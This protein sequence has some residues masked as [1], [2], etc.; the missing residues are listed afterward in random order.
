MF[1]RFP[2]AAE[3]AELEQLGFHLGPL[4]PHTSRTIMFADLEELL[5][6]V[7]TDADR[8]GYGSAV[9]EENVLGKK[10]FANRRE[11]LR[12]LRELYALDPR[13][14]LFRVFL[15]LWREASAGRPLLAVLAALARDPLLR[16]TA[17]PVV[18]LEPGVG[19]QR[20]ILIGPLR[21]AA[22]GRLNEA[23][24]DKV[25]RYTASS[26]T[27]AGL[28]EG[29]VLK[30]RRRTDPSPETAA[31]ALWLAACEGYPVRRLLESPWCRL[32]DTSRPELLQLTLQA[33]R[34]GYIHARAAGDLLMIDTTM[35]DP[36]RSR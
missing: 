23:M 15:R 9:V 5:R 25:A 34:L 24:I 27:Q 11:S 6:A 16:A 32:C 14:P 10:T 35:A 22:A 30:V 33:N 36:A 28:L 31:L 21:E 8:A 13:V 29:R 12:R 4:G 3:E 17:A 20:P 1:D 2:L 7:A 26:W 18:R 19:F